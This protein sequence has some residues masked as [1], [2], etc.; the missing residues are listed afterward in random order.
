MVKKVNAIQTIETS[1]LIKKADYDTK[2]DEIERKI[3]NHDIYITTTGFNN[4]QG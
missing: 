1:D 3:P 2:V 4:E